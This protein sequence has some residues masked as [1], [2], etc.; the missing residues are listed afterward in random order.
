[1]NKKKIHVQPHKDGGWQVKKDKA[2]RA[3]RVT[4]TK[5]EAEKAGR[6]QAKKEKT[7]FVIHGKDG[8]IQDSDSY[9][10]DPNPPKDRKQ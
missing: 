2:E 9:G 1:M 7:E 6:E 3:T 8:K 10:N 5:Q 4:E